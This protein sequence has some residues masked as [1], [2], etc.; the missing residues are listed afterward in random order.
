MDF[1]T[2]LYTFPILLIPGLL[3]IYSL[4]FLDTLLIPLELGLKY[5][6]PH[7]SLRIAGFCINESPEHPHGRDGREQDELKT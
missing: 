2:F 3:C 4:S 6:P 5:H 7:A 1:N